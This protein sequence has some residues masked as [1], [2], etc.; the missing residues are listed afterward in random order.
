MRNCWRARRRDHE[1][2][3]LFLAIVALLL[4]GVLCAQNQ[5]RR[6]SRAGPARRSEKALGRKVEIGEVRF[7]L[8]PTPGLTISN[9]TIGEDPQYRR[10]A[11]GLRHDTSGRAPHSRACLAGRSN[12]R[13]SICRMPASI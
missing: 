4:R 1:A 2:L 8:L 7:R 11:G 13:R 3:D 6:L 9:V 10:R 12:S 5:R